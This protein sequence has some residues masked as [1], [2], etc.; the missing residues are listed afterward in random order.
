MPQRQSPPRPPDAQAP[1]PGEGMPAKT[2]APGRARPGRAETPQDASDE[3]SLSLPHERD[4]ST[5]MTDPEPDP[6]VQQASTDLK[7]KLQDTGNSAAMNNTYQ[8]LKRD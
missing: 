8:K 6:Q 2:P 7:R 3:A 5:H 1:Y 4:Q